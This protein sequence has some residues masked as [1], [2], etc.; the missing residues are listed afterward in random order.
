MYIFLPQIPSTE[1]VPEE[2][3]DIMETQLQE[4]EN[5]KTGI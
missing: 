4:E 2:L 3:K 5:G 1:S